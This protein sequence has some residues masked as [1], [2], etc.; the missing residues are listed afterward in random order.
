MDTFYL[1]NL[2]YKINQN[3]LNVIVCFRINCSHVLYSS[4][5]RMIYYI[6]MLLNNELEYII[7]E[8]H[9]R[10]FLKKYL[11]NTNF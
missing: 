10:H 5:P 1:G 11:K 9:P 2:V 8:L 6:N 7:I 3:I 4:D